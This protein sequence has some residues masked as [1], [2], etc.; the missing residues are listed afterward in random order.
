MWPPM[1]SSALFARTTIAGRIPADQALDAALEV[2]A[3]RHQRLLV[4]GNRVDVRRVGGEGQLDAVLGR[5]K[6]QLAKQPRDFDRAAALQHII[7][8]IEPFA[9]FD[10]IELC[11]IFR[12]GNLSH[13]NGFLSASMARG[14]VR[15]AGT[16]RAVVGRLATDRLSVNH[17]L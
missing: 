8:G 4:G 13:G 1:P 10:G 12:S 14:E 7:E 3:A 9:G 16:H 6:R 2:G 5:V 17:S 15:H 11:G